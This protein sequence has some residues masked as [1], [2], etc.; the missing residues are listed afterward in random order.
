MLL[1]VILA[2]GCA[3]DPWVSTSPGVEERRAASAEREFLNAAPPNEVAAAGNGEASLSAF[4]GDIIDWIETRDPQTRQWSLVGAAGIARKNVDMFGSLFGVNNYAHFRALAPGR[5]LPPDA[6]PEL[7]DKAKEARGFRGGY[8]FPTWISGSEIEAIDWDERGIYV[9]S[10]IH[11]YTRNPDGTLGNMG[12][13]VYSS[14]AARVTGTTPRDIRDL[15]SMLRKPPAD[16][17]DGQ[18]WMDGTT[19]YRVERIT[20]RDALDTEWR[21]V[22]SR[23]QGLAAQY[24]SENVRLVVWFD[25]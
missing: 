25:A 16:W 21:S 22:F 13:S 11:T 14:E 2:A 18:E 8:R 10:Q 6:S 24:G 4:G 17:R 1:L 23:I 15:P 3:T 9:D 20:R 5:G 7:R 12:K 19:V